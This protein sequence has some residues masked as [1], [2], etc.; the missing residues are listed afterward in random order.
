MNTADLSFPEDEKV[1]VTGGSG[2]VGAHTVVRLL[3]E[4][5]QIRVAVRGPAQEAQV[6]AAL[7]QA[8]VDR[9]DLL[10]FAVADLSADDGWAQA[11]DGI[12]HVLHHASP[13]PPTPPE[14]EDEV[15]LPARD[16][17]LRVIS[18]ARGAGIPRVVMTSSFAAVG[19]TLKSDDHYTEENWTDPDTP[20]LPAYHKSKVLAETAA[21]D[22]VKTNGG[23]ELAVVNPTGIFGPQLVDRPSGSIGLIKALLAGEL[24]VVPI[25]NFGVV[26][27]RDVVDL[28]LRA[29]LHPNAAG[30]RFLASSG[31]SSLF[32]IA[33][34]LR[35][36]FPAIGDRLPATELTIEQ[37]REAAK[38]EPALKDAAVLEGRIPNI[39]HEKASSVLGWEPMDVK[40]TIV[41]TAEALIELGAVTLPG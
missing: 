23:I 26:D 24:S 12:A 35:E 32:K 5:H 41:A 29:M 1:L 9:A 2:F 7:Q 10:E 20:G 34:I 40:D 38:T 4:R 37:V 33:N 31:S 28:H 25:W 18:A 27:V 30:E 13:F 39:S 14:T 6:L 15:I 21:W 36:R 19:Y 11:M 3:R 22:Y 8:G 17:A 16:G